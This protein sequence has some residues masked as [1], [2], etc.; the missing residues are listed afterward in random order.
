CLT[1]IG[2]GS[3]AVITGDVTQI[4]LPKGVSSGLVQ[5]SKILKDVNG[6]SF[7]YFKSQDVVRH[8]I[9]QQIVEAYDAHGRQNISELNSD[10]NWD[11]DRFNERDH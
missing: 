1:R 10:K 5:A 2:V 4:D 9:V 11:N 8:P 7:T 3:T 6:V